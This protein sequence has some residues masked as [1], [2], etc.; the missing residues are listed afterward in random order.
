MIY[1]A[2]GILLLAIEIT[3]FVDVQNQHIFEESRLLRLKLQLPWTP[4]SGLQG[5][6]GRCNE[7]DTACHLRNQATEIGILLFGNLCLTNNCPT[8]PIFIHHLGTVFVCLLR[9]IFLIDTADYYW[10][11]F[12]YILF[13]TD[14][15]FI[16]IFSN[17][18]F[19]Y[20]MLWSATENAIEI[21]Y[22]FQLSPIIVATA[23]IQRRVVGLLL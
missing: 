9:Y 21:F 6:H 5:R 10:E 13:L 2:A 15:R 3:N 12:K 1:P 18:I 7:L 20:V 4:C 17:S 16:F 19:S 8:I 11:M 14:N 22:L 23:F